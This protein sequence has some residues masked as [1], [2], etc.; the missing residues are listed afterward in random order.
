MSM[1]IHAILCSINTKHREWLSTGTESLNPHWALSSSCLSLLPKAWRRKDVNRIYN[2][3]TWEQAV[4]L[5][6]GTFRPPTGPARAGLPSQ[7]KAN[8][9][10]SLFPAT[11]S[12]SPSLPVCLSVCLFLS[13]WTFNNHHHHYL[14]TCAPGWFPGHWKEPYEHYLTVF[15]FALPVLLICFGWIHLSGTLCPLFP[16]QLKSCSLQPSLRWSIHLSSFPRMRG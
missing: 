2:F 5:S 6:L 7:R 16:S 12:L 15:G 4:S 10:G 1:F 9:F 13:L 11:S 8:P 3:P 14:Y